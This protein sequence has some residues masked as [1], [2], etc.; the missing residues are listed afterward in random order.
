MGY[1]RRSCCCCSCS[2]WRCWWVVALRNSGCTI[3]IIK[4]IIRSCND[5]QVRNN[6]RKR[7]TTFRFRYKIHNIKE[8]SKIELIINVVVNSRI[9]SEQLL[10]WLIKL[11]IDQQSEEMLKSWIQ[12]PRWCENFMNF[13][14]NHSTRWNV[15]QMHFF[16]R[17]Q[18]TYNKFFNCYKCHPLLHFFSIKRNLAQCKLIASH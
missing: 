1:S 3:I 17:S 13:E 4:I 10:H 12:K 6:C 16:L 7:N 18:L 14:I 9:R 15:K 8:L 5:G 2:W 11:L